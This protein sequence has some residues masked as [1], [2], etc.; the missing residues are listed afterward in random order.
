MSSDAPHIRPQPPDPAGG[1]VVVAPVVVMTQTFDARPASLPDATAF[2]RSALAGAAD[3][4][5]ELRALNVAIVDALLIA[6]GP[7]IGSFQVV[8]RLF[9]DDIEIEV[10]SS[11]ISHQS[12]T[13][14]PT[15]ASF[16][17]WF[18][19]VLRRQG[20]S[21]Q[22]AARQLGVSVRTVSRWMRGQTEPRLRDV[23][24]ISGVFGPVPH[25]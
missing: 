18:S 25:R 22:T 6:A 15:A 5:T 16:A 13:G 23:G 20:M 3:D 11:S 17:E 19:E 8:I 24:R 21:Q 1:S 7:A 12:V 9:P 14:S 4:E 10:L 2:V